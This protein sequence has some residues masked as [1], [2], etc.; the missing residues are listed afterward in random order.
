MILEPNFT[1]EACGLKVRM[2]S[3]DDASFIVSLRSD[4]NRTKYMVTIDNDL[5]KQRDWIREY[6]KRERQGKD[7]YFIYMNMEGVSIGSYRI[8]NIDYV[9]SSCKVSSWIKQPGPKSEASAM[10]IVHRQIIFDILKLKFFFADIHK[11]NSNALKYY[12]KLDSCRY[13]E[14]NDFFYY[15]VDR[16]TFYKKFG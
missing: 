16:S 9:L 15:K 7:Y 3:E 11:E 10:F 8:S 4:L 14:D 13:K 5:H 6:K 12:E 2:I 1:F